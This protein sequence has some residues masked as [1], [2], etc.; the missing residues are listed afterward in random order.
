[1]HG[2]AIDCML[3]LTIINSSLYNACGYMHVVGR[4]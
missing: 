3:D 1:M 4:V 2:L